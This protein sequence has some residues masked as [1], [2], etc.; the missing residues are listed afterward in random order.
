MLPD[1]QFTVERQKRDNVALYN[2]LLW[3]QPLSVLLV[4][5]FRIWGS[6]FNFAPG[7]TLSKNGPGVWYGGVVSIFY[8]RQQKGLVHPYPFPKR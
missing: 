1:Q 8:L 6:T 4:Q 3:L 2:Q 7:Q 5:Y